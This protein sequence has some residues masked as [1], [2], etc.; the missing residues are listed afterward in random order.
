MLSKEYNH[1]LEISTWISDLGYQRAWVEIN[2]QALANNVQA[3][4]KILQPNTQLMAVVKADAYGHGAVNVAETILAA[5][6][7]AFAV[8]TLTEGIELRQAGIQAPILV[9]G[10]SN[11]PAEARAIALWQ[12]EPTLCN[13]QQALLYSETVSQLNICL[14]VHLKLDTGMSRLGMPWTEASNFAS[15]VANLPNL[16]IRSVYS[17][18][19][20]ADAVDP[21][22]MQLQNQRY[23]ESIAAIQ[24]I[25]ITP[26]YLHIANSAA[27]LRDTA[28]HY[29]LVRVGLALY[30]LY[31]AEH[32]SYLVDL[33]PV[34]TVKARI[35]QVKTIPPNTG[36]SYG[37]RFVTNRD[38]RLGVVGIG[39][40]DG[41][42]RLLS[43]K[44]QVI[45]K[46]ELVPQIGN[47]TM[48]QLMLDL[49]TLPDV[50]AGEVVTLIG[51]QGDSNITAED[52]ARML[53]TISWEI[54]CGF[55]H[56]LPRISR[57]S[58]AKNS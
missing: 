53:G 7:D 56:R 46:G 52:W 21:T 22:M 4:K 3:I 48:D 11:T 5:G 28:F 58:S 41:V 10:A 9:L 50:Q 57:Y 26:S 15:F 18:L 20:T 27:T 43:Q 40:A 1:D 38:L 51:K 24:S 14:P 8:A 44:L 42:P 23:Q 16:Q 39:Y 49:T 12:L 19:A 36:V 25:G 45:I 32:L 34:L 13:P 47:I 29:D 55:K 33:E 37:H 31:P 2:H 17:H 6:G 54:L 35:T 30:G